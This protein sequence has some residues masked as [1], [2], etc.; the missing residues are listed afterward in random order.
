MDMTDRLNTGQTDT[1]SRDRREMRDRTDK[2]DLSKGRL[3]RK[4]HP[5]FFAL[6][7]LGVGWDPLAQI[8]F[9]TF[10]KAKKLPTLCAGG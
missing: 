7:K 1:D 10:S 5:F 2:K 4:K 6:P 3:P 8:D 9:D